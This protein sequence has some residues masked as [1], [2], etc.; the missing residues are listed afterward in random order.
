MFKKIIFFGCIV[1]SSFL[2]LFNTKVMSYWGDVSTGTVIVQTVL[3]TFKAVPKLVEKTLKDNFINDNNGDDSSDN[4][5][6][7]QQSLDLGQNAGELAK[8]VVI[9]VKDLTSQINP[10]AWFNKPPSQDTNAGESEVAD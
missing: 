2:F 10:A 7:D 6:I 8:D 5:I 3:D 1:A 4:A 9:K